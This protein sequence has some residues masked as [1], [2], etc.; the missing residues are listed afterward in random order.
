M[1]PPGLES[2]PQADH[3]AHAVRVARESAQQEHAQVRRRPSKNRQKG[4]PPGSPFCVFVRNLLASGV[5]R[6]LLSLACPTALGGAVSW[7]G[8]VWPICDARSCCAC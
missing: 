8:D 2:K 7:C 5:S 3:T 6:G 4:E 1:T